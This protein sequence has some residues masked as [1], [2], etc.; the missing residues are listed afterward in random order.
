[1]LWKFA[2]EIRFSNCI[3][4]ENDLLTKEFPIKNCL[5]KMFGGKVLIVE[6]ETIFDQICEDVMEIFH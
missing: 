2:L 1:M 3:S 6:P 4:R 5:M